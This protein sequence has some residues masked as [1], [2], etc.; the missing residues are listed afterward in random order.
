MHHKGFGQVQEKQKFHLYRMII[1]HPTHGEY[2]IPYTVRK[3]KNYNATHEKGRAIA[4]LII[5][6]LVTPDEGRF[7]YLATLL[8]EDSAKLLKELT[9]IG[10]WVN[11]EGLLNLNP[12]V[13]KDLGGGLY[14]FVDSHVVSNRPDAQ[15]RGKEVNADRDFA[16]ALGV[17]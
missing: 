3:G 2:T 12:P 17:L 1:S 11:V 15:H 4:S 14:E 9:E 16:K 8:G 13:R 5:D 10:D 6:Y 7:L